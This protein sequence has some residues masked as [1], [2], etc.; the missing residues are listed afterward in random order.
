MEPHTYCRISLGLRHPE[1][2]AVGGIWC[3]SR[4]EPRTGPVPTVVGA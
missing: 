4:Y 1:V 3:F 2:A